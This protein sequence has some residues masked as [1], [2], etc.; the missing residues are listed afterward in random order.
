MFQ[1]QPLTEHFSRF[2][3]DKSVLTRLILINV[4]VWL[5]INLLLVVASLY[6]TQGNPVEKIWLE[7]I[8]QWLAVPARF[9]LWISKPWTIFTYMFLH[10]EF[11][12]LFFNML[13]L[14]WFGKIFLEFLNGGRLLSVYLIGGIFGALTFMLAYNI[15]PAFSSSLH[16]AIALGASASVLAIIVSTSV[17]V[18][19]Y[20]VNLLFIGPV[21]IRYIA[22]VTIL[23]DV[24]MI[25]SSNPGGHFAHLGGASAGLIYILLMRSRLFPSFPHLISRFNFRKKYGRRHFK[26]VYSTSKPLTDDEYNIRKA[27]NQKKIDLILDKVA[28][29]GYKSLSE[30]EKEFLF[31]FSN[32]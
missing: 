15:F 29:S 11:W 2:I 14:Y 12:H 9:D 5:V 23:L 21:K 20:T 26:T 4:G 31:K 27:Q 13:W 6:Q 3:K 19:D 17:M 18:P 28:K 32:K 24:F 25:R 8:Q 7:S 1:T 16:A 30:A 22:L 10:I